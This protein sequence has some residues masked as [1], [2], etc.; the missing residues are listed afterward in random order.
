MNRS[1]YSKLNNGQPGV[2]ATSQAGVSGGT[3]TSAQ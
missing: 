1:L 2:A 3:S